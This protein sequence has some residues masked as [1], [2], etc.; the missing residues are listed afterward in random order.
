MMMKSEDVIF[1]LGH[2]FL[3]EPVVRGQEVIYSNQSVYHHFGHIYD[4]F[5]E[6]NKNLEI[7]ENLKGHGLK[8]RSRGHE[9]RK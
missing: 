1:M 7:G 6:K 3:N 9:V 4:I 5:R 2:N 8:K